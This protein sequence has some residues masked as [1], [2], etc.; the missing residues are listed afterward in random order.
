MNALYDKGQLKQSSKATAVPL[1]FTTR[2]FAEYCVSALKRNKEKNKGV[3]YHIDP[4][5]FDHYYCT[6]CPGHFE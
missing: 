3:K 4:Y 1:T 2:P 6:L 5:L